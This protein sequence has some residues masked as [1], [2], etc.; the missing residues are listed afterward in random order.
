[1]KQRPRSGT[2]REFDYLVI[3]HIRRDGLGWIHRT[4]S[5]TTSSIVVTP[6]RIFCRPEPRKVIQVSEH[7][8]AETAGV[9]VGDVVLA[10]GDTEIDASPAMREAIAG[11]RWGD[12]APLRIRRGEEEQV[13]DVPFRRVAVDEDDEEEDEEAGEEE[14]GHGHGESAEEG[15]EEEA[16]HEGAER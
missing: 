8:P 10:L 1:M 16:E 7:S 9:E 4:V 15:E 3:L 13:L 12:V 5:R 11:Y 14:E 2:G 6:S